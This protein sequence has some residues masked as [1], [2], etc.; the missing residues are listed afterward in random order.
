MTGAARILVVVYGILALAATGRSV[1][2][3]I[4]KFD[5][6]PVAYSLSVVAGVVYIVATIALAVGT[7][8]WRR[9]AWVAVG[10]ELLGVLTV[11]TMSATLP[12]L[13]PHDSVWS[14]FGSGYLFVPLVLPVLGLLYLWRTRPTATR[15]GR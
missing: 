13:F 4:E 3:L 8:G 6:A 14:W 5:E 15:E 7:P 10:F 2:Q 11:G 12:A 1:Y 9:V